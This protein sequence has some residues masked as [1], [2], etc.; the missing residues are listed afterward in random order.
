MKKR[1][2]VKKPLNAAAKKTAREVSLQLADL[3]ILESKKKA[4]L[5]NSDEVQAFH[6]ES[7]KTSILISKQ[8]KNRLNE[9]LIAIGMFGLAYCAQELTFQ[10]R[11]LPRF[12]SLWFS[13]NIIA[14]A[15]SMLFA[16]VG[17]FRR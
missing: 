11:D 14:V 2:I 5:D 6:I 7:A 4:V 9:I 3:L 8:S 16:A 10:V 15:I 13:I 17:F 1:S 12:N